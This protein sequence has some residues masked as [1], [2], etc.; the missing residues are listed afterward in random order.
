MKRVP[1]DMSEAILQPEAGGY[2][3]KGSLYNTLSSEQ[4]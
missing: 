2:I 3:S 4:R 1:R